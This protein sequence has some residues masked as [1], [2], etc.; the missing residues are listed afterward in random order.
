MLEITFGK[1]EA[2][3]AETIFDFGHTSIRVHISYLCDP[4]KDL[5]ELGL[6]VLK[7]EPSLEVRFT[8]EDN[9]YTLTS[10]VTDG[11]QLLTLEVDREVNGESPV[12]LSTED[13]P[14]EFAT[15]LWRQL[16]QQSR[17]PAARDF[18]CD[19]N[20]AEKFRWHYPDDKIAE[21]EKALMT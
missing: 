2:G 11:R 19:E 14:R 13:A 10:E 21:M 16:S 1:I 6:R 15:M 12:T 4:F 9:E 3:W 5:A 17:N 7:N 8:D 18:M 20:C